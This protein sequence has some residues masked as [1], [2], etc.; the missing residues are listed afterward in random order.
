MRALALLGCALLAFVG[1]VAIF[2]MVGMGCEKA[3]TKECPALLDVKARLARDV[4]TYPDPKT[5]I[6]TAQNWADE[7]AKYQSERDALERLTFADERLAIWASKWRD[8]FPLQARLAR[9]M[10]AAVKAG[11]W[12]TIADLQAT[13]D[14]RKKTIDGI[15][16]DVEAY[17]R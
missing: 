15:G 9:Q 1:G 5:P 16:Q 4:R 13:W 10:S 17:C 2:G 7:G 8:A 6:E 14:D 11:D 3:R 12:K